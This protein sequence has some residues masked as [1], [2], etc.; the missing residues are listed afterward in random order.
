MANEVALTERTKSAQM[1]KEPPELVTAWEG[2]IKEQGKRLEYY[3]IFKNQPLRGTFI[4]GIT[5]ERATSV[6][7]T[8]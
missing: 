7:T 6:K 1:K 8:G 5:E 3:A 2:R 4:S